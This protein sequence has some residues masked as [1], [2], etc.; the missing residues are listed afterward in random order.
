[1]AILYLAI[2]PYFRRLWPRRLVSWV[3]VLDGRW[4]DRLVGRDL[5]LGALVGSAGACVVVACNMAHARFDPAWHMAV[6]PDVAASGFWTS[7]FLALSN[8]SYEFA[9]YM[10]RF[11]KAVEFTFLNAGLLVLLRLLLRKQVP[12]AGGLFALGLAFYVWWFGPGWWSLGISVVGAAL[13]IGLFL[14]VGILGYLAAAFVSSMLGESLLTFDFDAWYS[15]RSSV[16]LLVVLLV[17]V[18][19]FLVVTAGR[20]MFQDV[21]SER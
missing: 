5:L 6:R 15:A 20:P 9:E 14:R 11:R 7:P 1:M 4:R 18:W 21:L 13:F 10:E 8:P 19:G 12:A 3:C 17:G 2:E 16:T